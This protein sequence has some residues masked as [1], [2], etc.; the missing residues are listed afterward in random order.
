MQNALFNI[1]IGILNPAIRCYKNQGAWL[2]VLVDAKAWSCL[3]RASCYAPR[4]NLR[5]LWNILK[6]DI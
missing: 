4:R 1:L 5:A 6:N 3:G 2:L